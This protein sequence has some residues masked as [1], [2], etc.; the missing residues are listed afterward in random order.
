LIDTN[1]VQPA[2]SAEELWERVEHLDGEPIAVHEACRKY[3]L[4]PPSVYRWIE[5]GYIRDLDGQR[6]GGRGYKRY[7]NEADVAYAAAVS[8]VRGRQQ[9]RKVFIS[10][11]L[12]PHLD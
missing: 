1:D 10:K 4:T 8:D 9:G 2:P 6:G 5:A 3:D 12:P 11:Y 7:L